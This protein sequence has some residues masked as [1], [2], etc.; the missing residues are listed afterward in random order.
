MIYVW[1]DGSCRCNGSKNALSG[2][3]LVAKRDG[4]NLFSIGRRVKGHTN[5]IAEYYAV[6]H[7]LKELRIYKQEDIVIYS[8]SKL[9]VCQINEN[10]NIISKPLKYLNNV[11]YTILKRI[12]FKSLVF[13]WIPRELNKEANKIAQNI[14]KY[15]GESDA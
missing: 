4:K 1:V 9:V 5:N 3:G 10:W 15:R 12:V 6:I 8:D 11:V 14:T 13:K 2:I 7:A